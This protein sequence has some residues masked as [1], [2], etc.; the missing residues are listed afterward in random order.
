MMK[1]IVKL[2]LQK[3]PYSLVQ[4]A[5]TMKIR[6]LKPPEV[7]KRG[8]KRTLV[9]WT[10]GE[11]YVAEKFFKKNIERE[12]PL[13]KNEVQELIAKNGELFKNRTWETIKV[14]ICNKH[15][16]KYSLC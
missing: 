6:R 5:K 14:Y 13:K 8:S 11:K 10:K 4:T 7:V 3:E 12:I 1:M 9:P 2:R 16:K 15:A